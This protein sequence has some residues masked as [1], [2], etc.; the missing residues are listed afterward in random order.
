MTR[1]SSNTRKKEEQEENPRFIPRIQRM[2]IRRKSTKQKREKIHRQRPLDQKKRR[3]RKERSLQEGHEKDPVEDHVN[4]LEE[5]LPEASS[6]S[7]RRE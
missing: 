3:R 2:A 7:L 6:D 5:V 4:E 1:D